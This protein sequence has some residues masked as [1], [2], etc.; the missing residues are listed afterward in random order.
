MRL[1]WKE[2]NGV[3]D[4]SDAGSTLR[5]ILYGGY[6]VSLY[7]KV[8]LYCNQNSIDE[9]RFHTGFILGLIIFIIFLI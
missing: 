8:L 3:T 4:V 1:V 9:A 7:I 5:D 2:Y 6:R